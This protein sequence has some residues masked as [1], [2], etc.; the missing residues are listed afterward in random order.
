MQIE[1]CKTSKNVDFLKLYIHILIYIYKEEEE[2]QSLKC[3]AN[4]KIFGL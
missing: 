2:Y 3:I 4:E 1:N